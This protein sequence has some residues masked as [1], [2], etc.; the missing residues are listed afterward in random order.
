MFKLVFKR[1]RFVSK[2]KEKLQQ[3]RKSYIHECLNENGMMSTVKNLDI[4]SIFGSVVWI[5]LLVVDLKAN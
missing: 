3:V 5:N 4:L 1:V 2:Q